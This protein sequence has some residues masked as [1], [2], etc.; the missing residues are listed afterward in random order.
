MMSS[1]AVLG[2]DADVGRV[3]VADEKADG[4]AGGGDVQLGGFEHGGAAAETQVPR[5]GGA[6]RRGFGRLPARCDCKTAG[7]EPG[8]HEIH[9]GQ[10]FRSKCRSTTWRRSR[11]SG[12]F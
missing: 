10:A 11:Y 1:P 9:P 5:D 6:S 4:T 2:G 8:L 7:L 3:V 12:S